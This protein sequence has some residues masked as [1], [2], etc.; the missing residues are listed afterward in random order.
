VVESPQPLF[1][2]NVPLVLEGLELRFRQPTRQHGQAPH[3]TG[4]ECSGAP[5]HV[6]N[7]R[8]LAEPDYSDTPFLGTTAIM[9]VY[10]PTWAVRNCDFVGG[11]TNTVSR[12]VVWWSPVSGRAVIENC[13]HTGSHCLSFSIQHANVRNVSVRL[14]HNTLAGAQ[15][16]GF[17]LW[18]VPNAF[19]K[20]ADQPVEPV[21]RVTATG[22]IF[23]SRWKRVLQ[24]QTTPSVSLQEAETLLR[25]LVSW[26]EARNLYA[27]TDRLLYLS[28]RTKADGPPVAEA[29][30]LN[31]LEEWN[32]FWG[33]AD[34][35]SFGGLLSNRNA[36][37][38]EASYPSQQVAVQRVPEDYRLLPD[39]P[40]YRAGPDGNDL[41]ADVDLVGPGA[42]YE[43][44][45]KTPE[46][47]QW[48]KETG[49]KK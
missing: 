15:P 32:E 49:Q 23:Q 35:G 45:K 39:N 33:L 7:C 3:Q 30:R 46:Y 4:V 1:R 18:I 48:L 28:A 11:P 22:N 29:Y 44:W 20:P 41:G 14:V 24:L 37:A 8:F 43:R 19:T 31:S 36:S 21:L 47:Q 40:G 5:I 17:V 26:E 6:T 2:T 38:F 27:R 10:S 16:L 25:R 34:T 9:A 42:A 13:L 12:S